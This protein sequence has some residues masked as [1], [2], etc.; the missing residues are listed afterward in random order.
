MAGSKLY[1][2]VKIDFW[3]LMIEAVESDLNVF[4]V[5]EEEVSRLE[6][7]RE[8]HVTLHNGRGNVVDFGEWA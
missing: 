7:F 4:G 2:V 3:D 5:P 1:K 6:D 8:F